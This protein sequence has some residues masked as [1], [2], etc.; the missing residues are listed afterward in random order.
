MIVAVTGLAREARLIENPKIV[1]IIGGGD[2]AS[3]ERRLDDELTKRARRVLSIGICGALS[4]E[5][6]VGDV[7]VA[8]EVLSGSDI[9]P[10]HA[11]WTK[12]LASRMPHAVVAPL[13]GTDKIMADRE[14]KSQ[15]RAETRAAAADM[16]SHI[17]ARLAKARGLPFAALRVVSDAAH[18]SLPPA[19]SVAMTPS[20]GVDLGAVLRSMLRAPLQ[21]PALIRTAWEAEIAFAALFRCRHMLLGGFGTANL[22]ELAL[23]VG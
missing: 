23:D 3:L 20:G 10:T 7:I 14:A 19:T 1:P 22:G 6:R 18:R 9:F 17:A 15:L 5:F 2:G 12:D 13:V 4:P 8:S 11:G 21:I 16:E